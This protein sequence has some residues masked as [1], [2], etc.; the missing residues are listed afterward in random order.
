MKYLFK[1][2]NHMW[3]C[4]VSPVNGFSS[5]N[6]IL[7]CGQLLLCANDACAGIIAGV[8]LVYMGIVLNPVDGSACY[9]V[10]IAFYLL[11]FR[12]H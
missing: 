5:T 2:D 7:I 4:M 3:A 8:A 10:I 12:K 9:L 1:V 11:S 6:L